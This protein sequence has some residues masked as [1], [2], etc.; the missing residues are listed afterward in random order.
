MSYNWN[1]NM[2][3]LLVGAILLFAMSTHG[4]GAE[5]IN[6][7]VKD[8]K[9]VGSGKLSYLL[10]DVY[11]ATLYAPNGRWKRNK[12]FALSLSYLRAVTGKDIAD[13]T[14]QEIRKLG[15]TNEVKLAAW[16]RQMKRIFPNVTKGSNLTGIYT[17]NSQ[18]YFYRGKRQI[19]YIRDPEFGYWFFNIWLGK[20]TSQPDLK[21]KLTGR[22]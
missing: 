17:P 20:N 21:L 14:V 12:P 8:A 19:G 11:N 15:F 13:R 6:K 16:Y 22:R 9:V 10:W 7:Y 4:Y 5:H 2:H 18:T 1:F 3:R